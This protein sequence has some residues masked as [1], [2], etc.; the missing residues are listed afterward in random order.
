MEGERHSKRGAGMRKRVEGRIAGSILLVIVAVLAAGT[1]GRNSLWKSEI[2]FWE[3]C[4]R[5]APGKERVHHN[6]GF[7]YY[8]EARWED[9]RR[10]FQTALDLNPR[11]A[12]SIYN[13]GLV[14]YQEGMMDQAI[15]CYQRALALDDSKPDTY[16]NLGLAYYQKGC[17]P[18]AVDSFGALLRIKP[19]YENAHYRLGLAYQRLRKWDRAIESYREE[20]REN[21]EDPRPY[22]H[23]GDLYLERKDYPRAL[24][25]FKRALACPDLSD[26][27][28]VIKIIS[29]IEGNRKDDARRT[30]EK[31]KESAEG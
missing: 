9:A 14:F 28:R 4:V 8:E 5:K 12:L 24:V 21:P 27:D 23:L 25:H 17:Y 30:D 3:D 29:S 20:M 26:A 7:A 22:V 6:L 1:Y 31:R 11:Y 16:F 19:G 18:E 2:G 10:E 13:L 15:G